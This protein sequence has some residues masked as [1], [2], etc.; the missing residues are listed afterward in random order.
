[1]KVRGAVWCS[2]ITEA[3]RSGGDGTSS[4]RP[5]PLTSF[6]FS[7]SYVPKKSA[8]PG[9]ELQPG[10][11]QRQSVVS[12]GGSWQR[13]QGAARPRRGAVTANGMMMISGAWHVGAHPAAAAGR[14]LYTPL[15]PPALKNPC[16]G[17]TQQAQCAAHH[18]PVGDSRHGLGRL[19]TGL[20]GVDRKQRNIHSQTSAAPRDERCEEGGVG[21]AVK[22]AGQATAATTG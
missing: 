21:H 22:A 2:R 11:Q 10:N 9:T 6:F 16:R 1:M 19:C 17:A 3:V 8:A 12:C 4:V 5:M 20:D 14:P 7:V 13:R 18:T 15:K